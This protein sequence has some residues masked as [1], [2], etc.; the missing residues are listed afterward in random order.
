[1]INHKCIY[2]DDTG[3]LWLEVYNG[4]PFIHCHSYKWSKDKYKH[5]LEV[6][7]ELLIELKDKRI[8]YLYSAIKEN[9]DKL[10]KFASMFGMERT[11]KYITDSKGEARTVYEYKIT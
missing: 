8:P 5:Y 4:L 2:S 3:K 9:D 10:V 7:S 11:E 6:W 1:M